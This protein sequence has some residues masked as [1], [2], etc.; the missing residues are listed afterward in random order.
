MGGI[1]PILEVEELHV[2]YGLVHALKGVEVKVLQGEIVCLIGAN[3]AGKTTLLNAISGI[4]NPSK[5]KVIFRGEDITGLPP[6]KVVARGLVQ[7][8]E[9][10]QVFYDLTVMENLEMGAYLRL[11][12]GGA[13]GFREDVEEIWNLFPVLRERCRQAAGT[14][15]GGEQQML[16]LARGLMARPRLMMLDEPSLGLAPLVVGEI[17]RVIGSLAQKDT[18]VL[19]VEQNAKAALGISAK[20][21]VMETGRIVMS[22]ESEYLARDEGVKNAYLGGRGA[23]PEG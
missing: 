19:L 7:V 4:L 22:G 17:F 13:K 23:P 1:S 20:G 5:G 18:S 3:G 16:A 15:S 6:P 21:Y 14:L 9:G 11:S 8:P 10:R 12:R 2:H